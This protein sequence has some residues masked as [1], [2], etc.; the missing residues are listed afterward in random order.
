MLVAIVEKDRVVAHVRGTK[1]GPKSVVLDVSHAKTRTLA[2]TKQLPAATRASWGHF[3]ATSCFHVDYIDVIWGKAQIFSHIQYEEAVI[4]IWLCNRSLLNFLIQYMRKIFF[5]FLSVCHVWLLLFL[6]SQPTGAVIFP[7]KF[8]TGADS[9]SFYIYEETFPSIWL[10]RP[11]S[12]SPFRHIWGKYL[13][14]FSRVIFWA[15]CT[16]KA[17]ICIRRIFQTQSGCTSALF[18]WKHTSSKNYKLK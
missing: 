11:R 6:A 1:I 14:Y 15:D 3:L 9:E 17:L 8:L 18:C 10:K 13:T 4:H 5:S 7:E 12:H 2:D 16:Q